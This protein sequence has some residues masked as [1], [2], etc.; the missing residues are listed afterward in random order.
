MLELAFYVV[1]RQ[2]VRLGLSGYGIPNPVLYPAVMY[3]R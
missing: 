2:A 1:K 3:E